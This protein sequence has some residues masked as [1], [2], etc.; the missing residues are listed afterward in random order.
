MS[1]NKALDEIIQESAA[2]RRSRG[3]GSDKRPSGGGAMKRG[4]RGGSSPYAPQPRS[5]IDG[6]WS[7]DMFAEHDKAKSVPARAAPAKGGPR[8]GGASGNVRITNIPFAASVPDVRGLFSGYGRI[9]KF[10]LDKDADGNS[11][12]TADVAFHERSD[13]IKAVREM[14]GFS[15][16]GRTLNV[17]LTSN[18]EEEAESVVRRSRAPAPSSSGGVRIRSGAGTRTVVVR[19]GGARSAGSTSRDGRASGS[20]GHKGKGPARAPREKKKP[21]TKEDLDADM[22]S[23][24]QERD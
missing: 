20:A 7:H 19:A 6:K 12:G 21:V 14:N 23:W 2:S 3:G 1:L 8:A 13:A 22:D 24:G 11:L 18:Q 5:H 4:G 17:T 16:E 9:K 15:F 10:N